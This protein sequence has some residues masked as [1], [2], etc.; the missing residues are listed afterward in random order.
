ME[1]CI[2]LATHFKKDVKKLERAKV[3]GYQDD[4]GPSTQDH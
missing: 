3:E 2:V 4:Q 1:N